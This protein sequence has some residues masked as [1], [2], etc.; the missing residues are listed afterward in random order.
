MAII[1]KRYK[2]DTPDGV[3]Q[4]FSAPEEFVENSLWVTEVVDATGAATF[5]I[6]NEMGGGFY[7]LN[8]AP[9]VDTTL[10]LTYDIDV[11]NPAEE[12]GL[13]PWDNTRLN[14]LLETIQQIQETV[15]LIDEAM[16]LR[17][18]HKDFNTWASAVERKL[19]D[20][21]A[22]FVTE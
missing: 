1:T 5:R 17:V 22:M 3:N 4:L 11:E 8:P 12:D 19:K 18:T 7:Q 14:K 16:A 2:D 6:A 13:T 15:D 9:A 10:Y 20:V 21:E